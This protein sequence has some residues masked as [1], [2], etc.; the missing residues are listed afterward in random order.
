MWDVDL[1]PLSRLLWLPWIFSHLCTFSF[2]IG[3]SA[4]SWKPNRMWVDTMLNLYI[5]LGRTD[6]FKAMTGP[7]IPLRWLNPRIYLSSIHSHAI[8]VFHVFIYRCA[9]EV[10][11][12]GNEFLSL[13]FS[14]HHIPIT[15]ALGMGRRLRQEI[16]GTP[17]I[18]PGLRSPLS[19]EKINEC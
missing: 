8:K 16:K 13:S 19:I 11:A 2:R 4:S 14:W 6:V 3:L 17:D 15:L 5:S 1:Y 18:R 10:Y 7:S 12:V 9:T